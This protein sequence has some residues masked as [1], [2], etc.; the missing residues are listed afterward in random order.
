MSTLANYMTTNPGVS[1]E[2]LRVGDRYM[3]D[4]AVCPAHLNDFLGDEDLVY[5]AFTDR[6]RIQQL[7]NEVSDIAAWPYFNV[8]WP[9][10]RFIIVYRNFESDQA[11]D[12]LVE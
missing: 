6:E 4:P 2:V 10:G 5:T 3:E 1:M 12:Y 11:L 9:A 7:Y 8:T